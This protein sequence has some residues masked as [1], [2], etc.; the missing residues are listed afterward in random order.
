MNT[1]LS[2]TNKSWLSTASKRLVKSDI[3]SAKLDALIILSKSSSSTKLNIISNPNH[4]LTSRQLKT[5]D[6]L[7]NKRLK[8]IPIAYLTNCVEFYGY[9]FYVNDFVLIPRPESESFIN[10]LKK[11]DIKSLSNLADVGSGSGVLGITAKLVFPHLSV[12]LLDKSKATLKI[13]KINSNQHK[14]KVSI[15]Q[16]N[17]LSKS[18]KNIDIILANLPYVPTTTK[19]NLSATFEPKE[20]IFSGLDGLDLYKRLIPKIS[21]LINKPQFILIECLDNQI[22][23]ISKL[24]KTISYEPKISE[25]LVHVFSID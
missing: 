14:T 19:L 23:E 10:L 17:L 2:I 4:Q 11:I 7:L 24:F 6:R 25:G 9:N 12:E 3:E 15:K 20:A 1:N 18:S 22:I 5:A 21:E 16:S 13:S 8:G